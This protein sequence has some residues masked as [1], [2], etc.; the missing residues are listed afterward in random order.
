LGGLLGLFAGKTR[1]LGVQLFRYAIGGA[2]ATIAD[3]SIYA[4][5]VKVLGVHYLIGNATSFTAGVVVNY[6]ISIWWVFPQRQVRSKGVEFGL[7]AL[8]GLA[9]LGISELC[10]YFGVHVLGLYDLLTKVLA[11]GCTLVWNFTIRKLLLFRDKA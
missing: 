9:A 4:L 3:F 8:I 5:L 10:M 11:T 6:L 2:I 7:F 1:H